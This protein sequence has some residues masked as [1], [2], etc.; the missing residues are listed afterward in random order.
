[1]TSLG[2]NTINVP[3]T[4]LSTFDNNYHHVVL[5]ISGNI[6]TLYLDGQQ[7]AQ[8]TNAINI[9]QYYPAS[10]SKLFIGSAADLSYGFNGAIDDF[11]VYNRALPISDINEIYYNSHIPSIPIITSIL[12]TS[13]SITINYNA[14]NQNSNYVTG[15]QIDICNNSIPY[16]YSN[17][18]SA[19]TYS[20]L[21]SD[22]KPLT[23]YNTTLS[24]LYLYTTITQ[25]ANS[26]SSSYSTILDPPINISIVSGS[27]TYYSIQITLTHP[28]GNGNN[29]TYI[30][31]IGNIIG[32]SNP[33]T[34]TGLSSYTT[35][36][37]ITIRSITYYTGTTTIGY[38]LPSSYIPSFTTLNTSRISTNVIPK[39]VTYNSI[40][41]LVYTFTSTS[42][43]AMQF[44]IHYPVQIH[45]FMVG[46]GGGT[47]TSREYLPGIVP[48]VRGGGGA[49][50]V[51]N[52]SNISLSSNIVF[53][54]RI[55]SGGGIGNEGGQTTFN[56]TDNSIAYTAGGGGYGGGDFYRPSSGSGGS[57]GG[58]FW[59]GDA[60]PIGA[61]PY[62]S[63]YVQVVPCITTGNTS[64]NLHNNGG[65]AF[66][67]S[68]MSVSSSAGGGGA[69]GVGANGGGGA[70][71]D[72]AGGIGVSP[73]NPIFG[74]DIYGMGGYTLTSL[75][76]TPYTSIVNGNAANPANNTKNPNNTG[77]GGGGPSLQCPGF[78]GICMIAVKV[79]DFPLET[80]Q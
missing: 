8:N 63:P 54:I 49:G 6:H 67:G 78:N 77:N 36:N 62:N 13:N 3:S 14:P 70:G 76:S 65:R 17:Q 21:L 32:T 23:T 51:L 47:G 48:V 38:S 68:F 52:V 39:L 34:I 37:T 44:T 2:Y 61:D 27:N 75:A 15:Y 69:G 35:Y 22:L 73:S 43:T 20:I 7:I 64:N 45:L 18:H 57:S 74:T 1:M 55:G 26:F 66:F 5:S 4:T 10:I 50:G 53:N 28:S 41:Y 29:I 80:Y 19:S 25:I 58:T 12:P 31:N 24:S 79:I 33:Y 72:G 16:S 46:G 40:Q 9:F 30:S 56:A 60:T 42:T 71:G 11:R 59:L